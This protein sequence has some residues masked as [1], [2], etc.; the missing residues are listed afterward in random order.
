[1]TWS[2]ALPDTSTLA[3]S[4][5]FN[6]RLATNVTSSV[7]GFE[8][9]SPTPPVS[10]PIVHLRSS[11]L[12]SFPSC[13]ATIIL[14]RLWPLISAMA[15][16]SPPKL[17]LLTKSIEV[18]KAAG[19]DSLPP[20]IA[21][22]PK[23]A[24]AADR[25][26]P[27][28]NKRTRAP[29]TPTLV[30]MR[31]QVGR[32]V[33][34]SS[35]ASN[36]G[37]AASGVMSLMWALTSPESATSHFPS[38]LPTSVPFSLERRRPTDPPQDCAVFKSP[39]TS[40]G[41]EP[42]LRTESIFHVDGSTFF[43]VPLR[44]AMNPLPCESVPVKYPLSNPNAIASTP[45]AL[46]ARSKSS[47]RRIRLAL[48]PSAVQFSNSLPPTTDVEK[49]PKSV[50]YRPSDEMPPSLSKG[51]RRLSVRTEKPK[52]WVHALPSNAEAVLA[53]KDISVGSPPTT[54]KATSSTSA[55]SI[56]KRCTI[57]KS[58]MPSKRRPVCELTLRLQAMVCSPPNS[59]AV[60]G[61]PEAAATTMALSV[62]APSERPAAT[63]CRAM[64]GSKTAVVVVKGNSTTTLPVSTSVVTTRSASTETS[65]CKA[66]SFF[67]M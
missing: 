16:K 8:N 23:S 29:A 18:F 42:T 24:E 50:T 58:R 57:L 1:M 25:L 34:T 46:T 13:A 51:S 47:P 14:A 64:E 32:V 67:S 26:H 20:K 45:G 37:A 36:A 9:C 17:G 61:A 22:A 31:P 52:T 28:S 2:S 55:S 15:T 6:T 44:L 38:M 40:T 11:V 4:A 62:A 7:P 12:F 21:C 48:M 41:S 59:A 3:N 53:C 30:T 63:I 66:P 39:A 10:A 27:K 56:R 5:S 33:S 19:S 35:L 54:A 43:M 49:F 60:A 65:P